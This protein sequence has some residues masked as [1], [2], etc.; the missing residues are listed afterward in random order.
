MTPSHD[1]AAVAADAPTSLPGAVVDGSPDIAGGIPIP[2][3]TPCH[4][5]WPSPCGDRKTLL[6]TP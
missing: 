1:A 4:A 2:G 5:A 3:H 6:G